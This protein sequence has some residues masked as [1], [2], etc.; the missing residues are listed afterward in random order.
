MTIKNLFIFDAIVCLLFGLSFIFTPQELAKLFLTDPS[1][2]DGA[3]VTFRGYGILL[4]G[5]AFALLFARDSVPSAAKKGLLF[6]IIISGTLT[7][8]NSIYA[9]LTGI[10]NTKGW[11]AV[12]P[13]II[14][15]IW[16][17]VL[18][19]KEKVSA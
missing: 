6:F 2:T 1:L 17:I 8:I 18:L 19:P 10:E 15:T 3:I 16:G 7:S 12:I 11:F 13:V 4:C 9:V 14:I 5:G